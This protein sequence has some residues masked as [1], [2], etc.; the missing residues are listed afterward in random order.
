MQL[1]RLTRQRGRFEA[2]AHRFRRRPCC[3]AAGVLQLLDLKRWTRPDLPGEGKREGVGW[4]R[5]V[6]QS[7]HNGHAGMKEGR[8]DNAGRGGC[9]RARRACGQSAPRPLS[10]LAAITRCSMAIDR[11]VSSDPAHSSARR[12]GMRGAGSR[13]VSIR[14][15]R[16]GMGGA[17]WGVWRARAV[18]ITFWAV[19][20]PP[21]A[22]AMA[23]VAGPVSGLWWSRIRH[24]VLSGYTP[25]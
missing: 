17:A 22:A 25:A 4:R 23:S 13:R 18:Q 11:A 1:A 14:G 15:R 2:G 7:A 24:R 20:R 12:R 21:R 10:S 8:E 19:G 9:A 16:E 6:L 5:T 3:V